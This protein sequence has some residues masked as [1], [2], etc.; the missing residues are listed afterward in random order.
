MTLHKYRD[1][2]VGCEP[3]NPNGYSTVVQG[4]NLCQDTT[5]PGTP[6][7]WDIS[8]GGTGHLADLLISLL[9]RH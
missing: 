8:H 3:S 7:S 6:A 5:V 9:Q 1:F 4:S 2:F